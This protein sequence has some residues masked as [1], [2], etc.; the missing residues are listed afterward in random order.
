MPVLIVG[1]VPKVAIRWR[2]LTPRFITDCH[3]F[4]ANRFKPDGNVA[5]VCG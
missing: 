4:I 5:I 3:S 1:V 2:G